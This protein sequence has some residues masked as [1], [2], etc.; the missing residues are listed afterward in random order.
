LA[1]S[2]C[3]H[4]TG[5][6][7]ELGL[8]VL[9]EIHS[10]SELEYITPETDVVGVNNRNLGSFHTDVANSFRLAE[11]LPNDKVKVSESGLSK[12]E[13]VKQLREAGFRGFLMGEAFMKTGAPGDALSEFINALKQ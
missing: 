5:V 7:H 12:P 8:E 9:L 2:E 10:E 11:L 6:A 1:K 13:T 4:L 3:D